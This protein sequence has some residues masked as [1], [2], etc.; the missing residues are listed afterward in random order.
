M[1]D[2]MTMTKLVGGFCGAFLIFL[3]GKW[4]AEAIYHNEV[5]GHG[6]GQAA[7]AYVIEVA[8][9]GSEAGAAEET[10]D[11]ATLM[12]EADA[13]AGEKVFSKCRACHKLDG[14]DGTGPHLNGIVGRAVDSVG[15]YAYSGAIAAVADV[16]TPE[17]LFG[18]LENPKG[19]APGTKMGF[20]GLP[21]A[22]D[23]ANLIAYLESTG[24]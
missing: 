8:E 22:K 20:A 2:T 17:H 16:W 19:Y 12:A 18:F 1:F 15:G 14:T 10:V 7:M 21:K 24:G 4:A 6:D 3:F 23:R 13:A 11:L 5:D 9:G